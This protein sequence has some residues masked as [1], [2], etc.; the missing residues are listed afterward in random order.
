MDNLGDSAI[1]H[2]MRIS[3]ELDKRIIANGE[4]EKIVLLQKQVCNTENHNKQT[5]FAGGCLL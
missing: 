2:M 3:K 4:D 1:P 5:P